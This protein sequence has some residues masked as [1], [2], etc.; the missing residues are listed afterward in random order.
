MLIH[1]PK[2]AFDERSI[3][4]FF[5]EVV[6]SGIE[7]GICCRAAIVQEVAAGRNVRSAF[8][9]G[10]EVLIVGRGERLGAGDG[11]IFECRGRTNAS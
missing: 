5:R 11:R 4:M 6:V 8:A 9:S 1:D 3:G 2:A 10:G 7:M